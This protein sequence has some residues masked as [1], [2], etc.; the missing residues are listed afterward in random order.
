MHVPAMKINSLV[1]MVPCRSLALAVTFAACITISCGGGSSPSTT[2]GANGCG[3]AGHACCAANS[4][5]S[6]G[7]CVGGMC[8]GTGRLQRIGYQRNLLERIVSDEWRHCLRSRRSN[9]LRGR[10]RR[11]QRFR[12]R[13]RDLHGLRRALHQRKLRELRQPRLGVLRWR[14]RHVL[15]EQPFLPGERRR[16]ELRGVRRKRRGLL[17]RRHLQRGPRLRQPRQRNAAHV[18]GLRRP[19]RRVLSWSGPVSRVASARAPRWGWAARAS[20]AAARARPA[21]AAAAS[22]PAT[23]GSPARAAPAGVVAALQVERPHAS[24]AVL[25]GRLLRKYL[26]HRPR[27][28]RW[29]YEWGA[30]TCSACGARGEPCCTGTGGFGTGTCNTGLSCTAP[31]G[32]GARTCQ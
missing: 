30:P 10:C 1:E 21:V 32:G 31:D 5:S 8:I 16:N 19:R 3:T 24:R 4:C 27:L 6:G 11:R 13:R 23:R 12:R 26:Q 15:W 28:C 2:T 7:C 20:P 17:C 18:H 25:R 29:R 14:W 9:V 22:G